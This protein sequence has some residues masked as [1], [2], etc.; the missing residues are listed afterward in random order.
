M[1]A[2]KAPPSVD[3]SNLAFMLRE[4]AD[5]V[6]Q[7]DEEDLETLEILLDEETLARIREA[8]R[9]TEYVSYEEVFDDQL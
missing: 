3:L 6:Q 8:Q 1:P 7:L 9:C 2:T 5:K 4:L